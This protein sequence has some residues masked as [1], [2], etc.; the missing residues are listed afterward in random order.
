MVVLE[1]AGGV[2]HG[3]RGVVFLHKVIVVASVV[4]VMTEAG[5]KQAN[6]LGKKGRGGERREEERGGRVG[7][8][9]KGRGGKVGEGRRYSMQR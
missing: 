2:E 7:R 6:S 9:G 4:Q 5:D 3:Q 1:D 8:G